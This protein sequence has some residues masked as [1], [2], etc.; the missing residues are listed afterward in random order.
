[1]P[2]IV[3]LVTTG[4]GTVRFNPNL[5]Q[6]GKVCLSVLGTWHGDSSEKW[7]PSTSSL[8][9]VLVSI[10]TQILVAEPYF[11]EP[12]L[13]GQRG[14]AEGQLRS[15]EENE[16]LRLDTIR[17][18]IVGVL[19]S[20]TRK[21]AVASSAS[22]SSSS[23]SSPSFSSSENSVWPEL[24]PIFVAHFGHI[25]LRLFTELR[26]RLRELEARGPAKAPAAA[27]LRRAIRECKEEIDRLL[28]PESSP[29]MPPDF[30]ETEAS[31]PAPPQSAAA[32]EPPLA[33]RSPNGQAEAKRARS[34]SDS[35]NSM[36]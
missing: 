31:L 11:N 35:S 1:M 7:N 5:Y 14:T 8:Y 10:Q 16:K 19:R 21:G 25:R 2:P 13:E 36:T 15:E 20:H 27:R 34:E 32:V 26:L 18:A 4:H 33:A 17:H 12:G 9:Q 28:S 3:Q 30:M 6:D 29:P 23:S 24:R 22:A